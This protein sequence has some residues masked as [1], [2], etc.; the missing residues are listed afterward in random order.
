MFPIRIAVIDDWQSVAGQVADWSALAPVGEVSFL[1]E[2]PADTA[3][4]AERLQS[5]DVVCAMRERTRFDRALLTQLPRLRLLVTSGMRNAAIDIA[6]A[7]E[8]GISVAGTDGNPHA[9]PELAWALIMSVT[10]NLLAEA[11]QLKAGGWQ[12]GLGVGLH[13]RTLGILGLGKIGQKVARY[14]QAFGMRTIAWSE[15]LTVE[16]AAQHGVAYV[17]KPAL[18][19]QSDVLSI[20]LVL[21]GRSRGIVDAPL[22]SLMKPTAYLVNTARGPIVDEAALIAALRARRIAGAALD[23]FDQ[24]PL[25]AEHPFRTLDN[26]LAT[27]HIGYV[28]RESYALFFGNMIEDILA[29]HAGRPIRLLQ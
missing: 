8:L 20:H 9:A 25:P 29:W 27:P 7:G 21:G 5:Y 24:E 6:A 12:H 2:Y 23:V 18:F 26:V 4:L 3:R 14:A 17:E 10:R 11:N 15:N 22:L 13:G 28:T 1:H 16:R 19:A